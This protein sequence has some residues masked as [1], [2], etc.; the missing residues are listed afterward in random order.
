MILECSHC[1]APLDVKEQSRLVRCTYCKVTTERTR[2]RTLHPERPLDFRPPAVWTPPVHVPADS[3]VTLA[4]QRNANSGAGCLVGVILLSVVGVI[5]GV[6]LASAKRG[7]LGG[8]GKTQLA[9]L[10]LDKGPG[11]IGDKLGGNV[12]ETSIYVKLDDPRYEY[13]SMSWDKE[14]PDAPTSFY[15]GIKKGQKAP[16]GAA[17]RLATHLRGGLDKN[18]SWSWHGVH[19]SLG[20]DGHFN[21]SARPIESGSLENKDWRKQIDLLYRVAVADVLGVPTKFTEDEIRE[22]LAGGYP[23]ADVGKL[24]PQLSVDLAEKT[25]LEKFPGARR[26]SSGSGVNMDVPVDHPWLLSLE[27]EWPNQKGGVLQS[28]SA[29]PAGGYDQLAPRVGDFARCLTKAFGAPKVN[30]TDYLKKKKSYDFRL[31][32]EMTVTVNEYS[33]TLRAGWG[34]KKLDRQTLQA[35]TKA[36]DGCR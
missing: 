7:N 8:V 31:P 23:L 1:G 25:V 21:G 2:M 5:A 17:D 3:T 24:D 15:F 33:L 27:F 4:Y 22:L 10:K 35:F 32:G 34:D 14:H 36:L 16:T 18:H 20:E 9:A 13:L 28:V 12:S 26:G 30:D 29:H 19:F 6:I 11:G